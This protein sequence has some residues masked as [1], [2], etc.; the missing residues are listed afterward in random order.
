M[1]RAAN[2]GLQDNLT[3]ARALAQAR[4]HGLPPLAANTHRRDPAWRDALA[5]R[6]LPFRQLLQRCGLCVDGDHIPAAAQQFDDVATAAAAEID[7]QCVGGRRSEGIERGEFRPVP[8]DSVARMMMAYADG[9][10]LHREWTEL[11]D[12]I[13]VLID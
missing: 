8:I 1:K 6:Q 10:W 3:D 9:M 7:G 2:N 11:G 4:T 12:D 13:G 5:A